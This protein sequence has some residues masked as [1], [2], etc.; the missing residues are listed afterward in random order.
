MKRF[1]YY[2]YSTPITFSQFNANV[3]EDWID[4]VKDGTFS[5]GG[6]RATEIRG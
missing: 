2:Y 1:V 5:H 3:P 4:Q 6:Y